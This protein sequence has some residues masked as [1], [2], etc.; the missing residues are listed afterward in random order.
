MPRS[1]VNFAGEHFVLFE[2]TMYSLMRKVKWWDKL[3]RI[4]SYSFL[5]HSPRVGNLIYEYQEE[6]WAVKCTLCISIFLSFS[7]HPLPLVT[8]ASPALTSVGSSSSDHA[9]ERGDVPGRLMGKSQT[10][11]SSRNKLPPTCRIHKTEA[12]PCFPL[13]SSLEKSWLGKLS[14]KRKS[15]SSLHSWLS[16]NSFTWFKN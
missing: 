10:Q 7:P 2:A 16:L 4:M 14:D 9:Q 5:F 3:K 15:L 11:W 1:W 6:V 12:C 8:M 13:W